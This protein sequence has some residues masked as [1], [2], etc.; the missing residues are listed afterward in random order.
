MKQS[1]HSKVSSNFFIKKDAIILGIILLIA[2]LFRLYKIN[3]PL[4]DFHSFRQVDTAAVARNFA[5]DGFDLFHPKYDDFSNVQSGLENPEGYRFV[6]FP[7][8]NAIFGFF[9]KYFPVLSIETYGRLTSSVFSLGIISIIYFLCLKE[10]DR[11]T[12]SMAAITYAVMPLFV[13]FSR[14]VLPDTPATAMAFIS[15]FFFYLY[16]MYE[17]NKKTY[18]WFALGTISF[19]LCL[20]IKPTAGFYGLAIGLLFFRKYRFQMI[21]KWEPYVFGILSLLPFIA[22]R[23][24][25][26]QFPEGIPASSW[27]ITTVNTFEGPKNIFFKPAFFRWIFFE[28]I[29]ILMFG[30]YLSFFFLLG[31][32]VKTKKYFL[33]AILACAFVYLFTFQG[34]N[35]QHEYY[36]T[37]LLPAF[38]IFIGLGAA[39]IMQN[40]QLFM[41]PVVTYPIIIATFTFSMAF[42]FYKVK[43]FYGYPED[44][45]Q[46]AKIIKTLTKPTD[47]IVTDR[48]GDTTLLYLADRKGAPSVYK[49]FSELKEK[50]YKYFVTQDKQVAEKL[51]SEGYIFVF[52]NDQFA[53]IKF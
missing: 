46:I 12:A 35:V 48:T 34:G 53:L 15:L 38:A 22:W 51:K 20:L 23:I 30:V 18:V 13:F 32:I 45:V 19:A 52:E 2:L 42:S 50:K 41:H 9:Y 14:M 37:I 5:R 27:L 16:A 39:W 44:L 1:E 36:Q 3:T 49:E 33:H 8:Y 28:R 40:T 31:I 17:Q 11:L 6:E 21:A 10:R 29:G 43:D 25:I 4:A 47:K 24:Y 26:S 7:I